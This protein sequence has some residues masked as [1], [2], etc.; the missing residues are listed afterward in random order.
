MAAPGE[1][2]YYVI[3]ADGR[4][5]GPVTAAQVRE[6]IAAGY[7]TAQ[8]MACASPQHQWQKLG[9]WPEF[10]AALTQAPMTGPTREVPPREFRSTAPPRTAP[11]PAPLPP[12]VTP[13]APTPPAHEPV[14]GTPFGN[15]W[16]RLTL[17]GLIVVAMGILVYW[18]KFS[19][20]GRKR[21]AAGGLS[22]DPAY[23]AAARAEAAG[24]YVILLRAANELVARY[25]QDARGHYI[26]GVALGKLGDLEEAE[27]A[28]RQALT[29]EP[30][31]GD[32]W[33]NLGWIQTRQGRFAAAV[34]TFQQMVKLTPN[35]PQAWNNLGGGLTGHGRLGEAITAYRRAVEL[36]PDYAEAHYNLGA[37]YA[38]QRQFVAAVAALQQ[39]LKYQP[40]LAAAWYNLGVVS[41]MQDQPGEAVVFFQEATRRQPDHADA[42]AGLVS[43]YLK[44]GRADKASAA[45]RELK[46]LDPVQAA[47]LADELG[48]V[49]P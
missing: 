49:T 15:R 36:K 37:A 47:W 21:P 48:Q 1:R 25:P 12:P 7:L 10:A 33:N 17:L 32:A 30:S 28:F 22:E 5:Y 35:D 16:G 24:D 2:S 14:T 4:T 42:W 13:V 27:L 40:D 44:L 6:W 18:E 39:A 38:E 31:Y 26:R 23:T 41:Q 9:A 45:A 46:R 11:A 29:R 3:A 34:T 8:T 20:G 19:T 43:A